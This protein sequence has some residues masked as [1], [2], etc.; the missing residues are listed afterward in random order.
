VP[1]VI[2]YNAVPAKVL[3]E[4]CNLNN[5]EDRRQLQTREFRQKVAEAVVAALLDY[6]GEQP[7]PGS[8]ETARASR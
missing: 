3:V 5:E 7:A 2:R 8:T 4:I 6:Y 1:A